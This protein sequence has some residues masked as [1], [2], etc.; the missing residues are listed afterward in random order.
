MKIIYKNKKI[1]NARYSDSLIA[2]SRGLMFSKKLKNR[3]AL[4][5]KA[6]KEGI[7]ETSL[8][9]LFVLFPIDAIW[10][11][12]KMKIVDIK[13][14]IKP[15]SLFIKPR[16]KARYVIEMNAKSTNNIKIGEL[17]RFKN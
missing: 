14:N 17:I 11:N 15:F 12:E 2:R 6:D 3:E 1:A 13:R 16:E 4:I 5:L 7:K 10:V 9:M 8:H